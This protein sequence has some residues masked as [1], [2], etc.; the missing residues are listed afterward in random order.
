MGSDATCQGLHTEPPL[1]DSVIVGADGGLKD[2]L[3]C[4][5]KGLEGWSFPVPTEVVYL[6][7]EGC[8]YVPHVLGIRVDQP[9]E[10]INGDDVTH[11]VHTFPRKNNSFN[12]TQAKGGANLKKSFARAELLLP[13]KC[14]IHGWMSSYIGVVDNPFFAVS[15]A[16]GHFDLGKLP[17]GEYTIE[18]H[19][20][21]FG[22]QK[23]TVTV[24]DGE[25][26]AIEFTF[27]E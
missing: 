5:R 3:V 10:I 14:D 27:S 23:Q 16:D 2:V 21:V 25:S 24:A 19:H 20:E 26:K 4:V 17:P 9:L 15:S 6:T 7:Q 1:D 18:A 22:R 12:Q 13:V 8:T 11:N